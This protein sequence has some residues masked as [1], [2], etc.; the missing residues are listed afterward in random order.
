MISLV[1]FGSSE[2][3]L[4]I[5][6]KILELKN[7]S[8]SL[9]VSK[10]D[11]PF[12][13]NQTIT[14]NPVAKFTRDHFLPLL[15][16]EEFNRNSKLEIR[17][18]QAD[19]GLCVAFGPPFFD[20]ET[21]NIFP[22]KIVNIHPS[23]LPKY[24]GATPGPWQIINGETTS[25]VTFFQIDPLPDHGPI[26]AS[27]PFSISPVE[28]ASS[29][30]QKAFTL[31][32]DHLN[33]VLKNHISHSNSLTPQNHSQKTYFPKLSK[34]RALIDWSWTPAKIDRFIRG[35][36]PWPIA[37]TLAA[38]HQGENLKMKIFSYNLKKDEPQNV[39]IE[40]K[41]PTFWSKIKTHY[42]IIK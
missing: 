29:F 30:Y 37:W 33:L 31:A 19:L 3:S 10:T 13:R 39:Q 27:I 22:H 15:Q 5:L 34:D 7:F 6:K 36:T 20:K 42:S 2:Y 26:I 40:G 25:A 24:R 14:P 4:I 1:F 11:K 9:V 8:L 16:I 17:N 41:K 18:S 35:L 28:T 12:G 23:P 38:N 21:I 32:A